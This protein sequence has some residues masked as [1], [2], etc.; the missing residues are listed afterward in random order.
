MD[1]VFQEQFL[2][3]Q[4]R[5]ELQRC[6]AW[7]IPEDEPAAGDDLWGAQGRSAFTGY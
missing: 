3:L 5:D 1:G 6:C 2:L 7:T 4:L